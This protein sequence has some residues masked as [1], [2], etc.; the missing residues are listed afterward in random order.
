[1]LYFLLCGLQHHIN[2]LVALNIHDHDHSEF[3]CLFHICDNYFCELC[4]E[5]IGAETHAAEVLNLGEESTV[6]ESG[7]LSVQT[8]KGL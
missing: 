4:S 5:G 1:M 3:K 7:V 2:K 8:S 6:W